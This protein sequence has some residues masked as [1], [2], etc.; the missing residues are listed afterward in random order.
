MCLRKGKLFEALMALVQRQR[1]TDS[2]V[3]NV[4][5]SA[6]S[7]AELQSEVPSCDQSA[8]GKTGKAFSCAGALGTLP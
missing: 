6:L 8:L 7:S 5:L 4:G 1:K 2:M 3:H